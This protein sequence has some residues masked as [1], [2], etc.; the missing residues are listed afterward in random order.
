M[1]TKFS[2]E[3]EQIVDFLGLQRKQGNRQGAS[4][5]Q[6][7]CPFCQDQKYHMNINVEKNAYSCTHCGQAG[8]ALDLYG[9]IAHNT[10]LIP[11][12][13]RA[14]GNGDVLYAKLYQDLYGDR[15]AEVR[16]RPIMEPQYETAILRSSDEQVHNAYHLLLSFPPFQL[17]V[18]HRQNLMK[19]GLN[20]EVIRR[21]EY[22]SI[23]QDF[24]WISQ[25]PREY[26]EFLEQDMETKLR[27]YPQLSHETTEKLIA[28]Y[29]VGQVLQSQCSLEGVPGFYEL[30]GHW[31][32]RVEEGM[33]IPTRNRVGEIVG[34]Q[35]RKDKGAV[36]YKTLSSKD[37]P[38][39]VTERIS[40]VHFPLHQTP[41]TA[42]SVVFLTEGPLKADVAS[43]LYEK[44][45]IFFA[46]QGVNNT[47]GEFPE[48]LQWLHSQGVTTIYNALDMDKLTNPNVAKASRSIRNKAKDYGLQVQMFAWDE[49]CAWRTYAKLIALCRWHGFVI[50]T[51]SIFP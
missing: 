14:G 46:I 37:L 4:S 35:V 20:E 9:R 38:K 39:G 30:D 49:D 12:K 18:E 23:P 2:I 33:M 51:F 40:R 42:Q 16:K 27:N 5:Y 8:G 24:S 3:I 21:N 25:Y 26:R 44:E 41:V 7:K 48:L 31:M 10:P 29:I 50:W 11:G 6:V 28:G 32:V 36:R 13:R 47:G 22:R 17:S 34:L 1:P 43:H 45:S 15:S 19:R